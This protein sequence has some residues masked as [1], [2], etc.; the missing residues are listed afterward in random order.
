MTHTIVEI[1]AILKSHVQAIYPMSPDTLDMFVKQWEI[2]KVRKG[3]TITSFGDH[4]LFIYFV[5]EGVQRIYHLDAKGN[6]TNLIFSYPHTFSGIIDSALSN[7]PSGYY[8]GTISD[9]VFL[10][11]PSSKLIEL[12]ELHGEIGS[13]LRVSLSLTIKGL[14]QRLIER[15]TLKSEDNFRQLFSRNPKLIHMIPHK[16]LA[17]YLGM[18]AT[19]FSKFFNKIKL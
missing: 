5:V 13:F 12:G 15:Q 18:D 11:I 4:E 10:K 8:F 2:D 7:T 1:Y 19:N 3:K 9:S 6:E 17:S 14:L 16:H